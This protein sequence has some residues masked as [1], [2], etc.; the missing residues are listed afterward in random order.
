M[1]VNDFISQ[2]RNHPIIFV[3]T[4]ISLRYLKN[5]YT[6]DNLLSKVAFELT[7]NPEYYF[8]IKSPAGA[9]L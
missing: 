7:G 5:S 4:G 9:G 3:G 6:W 1:N 8:D 2:Y